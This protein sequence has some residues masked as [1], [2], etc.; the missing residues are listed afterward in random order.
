V[1]VDGVELARDVLARVRDVDIAHSRRF[2]MADVDGSLHGLR[3]QHRDPRTLLLV[4]RR[5]L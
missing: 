4:S 2:T 5:V 3:V 1:L